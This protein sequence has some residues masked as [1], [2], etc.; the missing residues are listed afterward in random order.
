MRL[1][2]VGLLAVLLFGL[3]AVANITF[4]EEE[5][6]AMH[7]GIQQLQY[8]DSLN[9]VLIG[10]LTVQL[11]DYQRLATQ[12][13]LIISLKDV[14]IDILNNRLVL[15][16]EYIDDIEPKWYDSGTAHFI[17]GAGTVILSSYVVKNV[18]E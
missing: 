15:Y 4:T 18:I 17:Y 13:S 7:A 10:E 9:A 6:L 1:F 5:V 12:D 2:I 16:D 8:S 3:T 14:H 11:E